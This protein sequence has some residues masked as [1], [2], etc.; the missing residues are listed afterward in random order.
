M[1]KQ[2]KKDLRET[3]T[4]RPVLQPVCVFQQN[5]LKTTFIKVPNDR[6]EGGESEAEPLRLFK[7]PDSA[8][9]GLNGER[10]P[11]AKRNVFKYKTEV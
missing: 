2:L 4:L 10:S 1:M 5:P 11:D 7:G 6:Q 9:S 8:L 3:P